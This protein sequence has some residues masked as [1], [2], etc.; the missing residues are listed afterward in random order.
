MSNEPDQ[1]RILSVIKLVL[2]LFYT[3]LVISLLVIPIGQLDALFT[4]E[5]ESIKPDYLIHMVIF[6]ALKKC[7]TLSRPDVRVLP[8]GSCYRL[9]GF[10]FSGL[11]PV[12][13]WL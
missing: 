5:L 1:H 3:L 10:H 2:I 13:C 6:S 9:A 4:F 11:L 7:A 8:P 12:S